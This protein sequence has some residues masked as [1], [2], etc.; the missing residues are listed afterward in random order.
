MNMSTTVPDQKKQYAIA[1][2]N[3]E[4]L[5]DTTNDP[6]TLDDDFTPN[7]EKKWNQKKLENKIT[8]LSKTIL[9]IGYEET[10]Q[11]PILVGVAEVENAEVLN[12]LI[13]SKYLKDQKYSFVHFDS[14]DERGIDT[15]LLYRTNYFKILHQENIEVFI[16]NQEGKRDFTRDI[17][18]IKGILVNQ[19]VH[20]LINHWPSRRDGA[21]FTSYKREEVAK[22]N[23]E[24]IIE[25]QSKNPDAKIIVMGDFNDDPH[26][27]SISLL[28]KNL[29]YNPME[30]LLTK[31]QGSLNYHGNW[32][33]F[34]QILLSPNFLQQYGN[35]F[36]FKK[37]SIFEPLYLK[38]YKG[39]YKGNPFRTYVGK[40]YLGGYSDHFPVYAVLSILKNKL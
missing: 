33:L 27:K 25:I 13:N 23:Q 40:K 6:H 38:E 3:L 1:F 26:S 18:Y 2:Y 37:A 31:Y 28:S 4:N 32:N 15:A 11:A 30:L 34:D 39:K 17:L 29:L 22:L 5:F 20:L 9:N 12:Q 36:R 19:T 35:S 14:P 8:K 10:K 24:K 16:N 21:A 7:S